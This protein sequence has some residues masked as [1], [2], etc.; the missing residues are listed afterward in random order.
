MVIEINWQIE[1]DVGLNITY[2]FVERST[3]CLKALF[4][5]SRTYCLL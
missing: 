5:K 1:C 4:L 2:T 3:S